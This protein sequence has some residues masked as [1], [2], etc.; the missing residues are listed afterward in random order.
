ML[1]KLSNHS[2]K[3]IE[4]IVTTLQ[5]DIEFARILYSKMDDSESYVQITEFSNDKTKGNNLNI[6]TYFRK[7]LE[8]KYDEE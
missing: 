5:F 1:M 8:L 4:S 2:L 3:S 6:N 7:L